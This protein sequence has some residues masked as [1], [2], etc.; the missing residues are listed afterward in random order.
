MYF[1]V[2]MNIFK[3]TDLEHENM[4]V[5]VD[6]FSEMMNE[7]SCCY[8]KFELRAGMVLFE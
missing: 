3:S 7:N 2:Y 6:V 5:V 8:F 4:I 1:S